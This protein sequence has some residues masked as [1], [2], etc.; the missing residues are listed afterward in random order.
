MVIKRKLIVLSCCLAALALLSAAGCSSPVKEA[1]LIGDWETISGYDAS[2]IVFSIDEAG[3]RT[4]TSYLHGRLYEGGTWQLKGSDLELFANGNNTY[5]FRNVTI[6]N[7]RL[8]FLENGKPASFKAGE[9][10]QRL[11]QAKVWLQQVSPRFDPK[12]SGPDPI[13][14]DW[15]YSSGS[16][17]LNGYETRSTVAVNGDYSVVNQKI[18]NLFSQGFTMDDRNMTEITSGYTG[19]GLVYQVTLDDWSDDSSCLVILRCAPL[20]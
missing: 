17:R 5:F 14:F 2:S 20:P 4:F 15:Q 3:Q 13:A 9:T 8:T 10:R 7:N 16:I 19:D 18:K 11:K 1:D 6:K 12:H